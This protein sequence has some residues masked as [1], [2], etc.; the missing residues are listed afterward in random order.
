LLFLRIEATFAVGHVE[1]WHDTGC[2]NGLPALRLSEGSPPQGQMHSCIQADSG[3]A[4]GILTV[5]SRWR[6]ALPAL[7]VGEAARAEQQQ[8]CARVASLHC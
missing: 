3:T 1:K 2:E 7:S 8:H 4:A 6:A 5:M